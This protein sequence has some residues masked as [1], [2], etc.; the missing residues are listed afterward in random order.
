MSFAS[1]FST[2]MIDLVLN[3]VSD[4]LHASV[5]SQHPCLVWLPGLLAGLGQYPVVMETLYLRI[6]SLLHKQVDV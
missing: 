5:Q 6:W 3:A 2:Q 4:G 1:T